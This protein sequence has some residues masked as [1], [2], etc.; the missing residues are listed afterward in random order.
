MTI[1]LLTVLYVEN[2]L[3]TGGVTLGLIMRAGHGILYFKD[4]RDFMP[5]ALIA[6][7]AAGL[8]PLTWALAAMYGLARAVAAL[9]PKSE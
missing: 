8:W 4:D 5:P 9:L 2:A 6:A 1:D 7:C 3:L